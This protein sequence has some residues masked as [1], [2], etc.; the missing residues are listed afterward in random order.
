M[1]T[2]DRN[3]LGLLRKDISDMLSVIAKKHNITL[4]IG[5]I[6]FSATEF[7]TKLTGKTNGFGV[8]GNDKVKDSKFEYGILKLGLPKNIIGKSFTSNNKKYI[9]TEIAPNR[10]KYPI[11]AKSLADGKQYK[12]TKDT[13]VKNLSIDEFR[14]DKLNDLLG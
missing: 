1:K 9:I 11:I 5:N 8:I 13:V 3:E 6:S 2:F 4:S 14:E 7:H 12:F 10:P